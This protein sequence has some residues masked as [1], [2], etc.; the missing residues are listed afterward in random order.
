M[1][2]VQ[3]SIR[4]K[5]SITGDILHARAL[6]DIRAVRT[7]IREVSWSLSSSQFVWYKICLSNLK[8]FPRVNNKIAW[9]YIF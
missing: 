5:I 7:Y 8:L 3:E 1:P 6:L 4:G 2:V 9:F